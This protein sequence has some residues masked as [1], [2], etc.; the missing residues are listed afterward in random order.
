MSRIA[1]NCP[2]PDSYDGWRR[3]SEKA[4]G[5][6]AGLYENSARF[7]VFFQNCVEHFR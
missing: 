6:K 2:K 4:V 3:S 5:E 7:A 1:D